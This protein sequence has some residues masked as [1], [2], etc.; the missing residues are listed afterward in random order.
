M[1][2]A[3]RVIVCLGKFESLY[4]SVSN[5][6]LALANFCSRAFVGTVDIDSAPKALKVT[7][8]NRNY[9]FI[10]CFVQ[11]KLPVICQAKQGWPSLLTHNCGLGFSNYVWSKYNSKKRSDWIMITYQVIHH[12][13]KYKNIG[14]KFTILLF[15]TIWNSY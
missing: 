10:M 5:T 6:S 4:K 15:S 13:P 1:P 12:S 3:S 9:M 11:I 14:K 8:V 2:V 7:I